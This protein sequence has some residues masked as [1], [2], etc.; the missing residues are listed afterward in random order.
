MKL[1]NREAAF[2]DQSEATTR[3]ALVLNH[4]ALFF[5]STISLLHLRSSFMTEGK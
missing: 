4:P 5:N 2:G 3:A 1:V